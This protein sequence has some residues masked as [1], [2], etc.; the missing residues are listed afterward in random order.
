MSVNA[1]IA[2]LVGKLR[3]RPGLERLAVASWFADS[4]S[5]AKVV[6]AAN[7]DRP[8]FFTDEALSPE[9]P[10]AQMPAIL[11]TA[12]TLLERTDEA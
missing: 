12:L 11:K 1:T 9:A 6:L 8:D 7:L 5:H 2:T 4:R 10:K 3:Q